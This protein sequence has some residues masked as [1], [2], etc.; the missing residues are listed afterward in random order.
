MRTGSNQPLV[1]QF[2]SSEYCSSVDTCFRIPSEWIH[3]STLFWFSAFCHLCVFLCDALCCSD[4]SLWPALHWCFSLS[5]YLLLTLCLCPL[6]STFLLLL[7]FSGLDC[8]QEPYGVMPALSLTLSL[9]AC[10][11]LCPCVCL[12]VHVSSLLP[13]HL[14]QC[15]L[16]ILNKCSGLWINVIF[17]YLLFLSSPPQ[18]W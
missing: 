9:S 7:L 16:Q 4:F 14:S 10:E 17:C 1:D 2:K 8:F 3:L 12:P 5:F 13:A 11:S 18:S 15:T 6:S